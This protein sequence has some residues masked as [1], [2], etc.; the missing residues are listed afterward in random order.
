MSNLQSLVDYLQTQN[1]H[2]HLGS[3]LDEIGDSVHNGTLLLQKWSS[4]WQ[5]NCILDQAHAYISRRA[6]LLWISSELERLVTTHNH[7]QFKS[8]RLWVTGET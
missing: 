5:H 2:A 6:H 1:V 8:P 3:N 7:V 4:C